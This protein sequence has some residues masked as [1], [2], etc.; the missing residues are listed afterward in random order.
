M[1]V[2]GT[3]AKS[4]NVIVDYFHNPINP[5]GIVAIT[6]T[7]SGNRSL[8]GLGFGGKF[9]LDNKIDL[10]SVK[11][12]NDNWFQSIPE[13]SFALINKIIELKGYK[14]TVAYGSSMG[15]YAAIQ[16]SKKFNCDVVV[17]LSPQYTILEEFDKRW[18]SHSKKIDWKYDITSEN[19]SDDCKYVV[20]YDT[21]DLDKEHADR[22]KVLFG[23]DN[24]TGVAIPFGGHPVSNYLHES[25]I[26]K[27][28]VLRIFRRQD[29]GEISL[30]R[31]KSRSKSYLKNLSTHLHKKNKLSL[32]LA[33]INKAIDLDAD[34]P[35]Y[36]VHKST[37]LESMGRMSESIEAL[38]RAAELDSNPLISLRI[39]KLLVGEKRFSEALQYI[40]S[41]VKSS[42][43]MAA[44][45]RQKSE[46]LVGLEE[47]D[48][49]IESASTASAL[50]S[51]NP[52]YRIHLG[53][54]YSKQ[55]KFAEALSQINEGLAHSPNVA[56]LYR[57]KVELL[58][59]VGDA[60]A[61]NLLL[62][63]PEYAAAK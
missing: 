53:N 9:L 32:S 25:G 61:A 39:S 50:D 7:P 51:K 63:T 21:Y 38:A 58:K 44:L 20:F 22:L 34:A 42:G 31:N 30:R 33:I 5:P 36:F 17:A 28:L 3:I 47:I 26:L 14:T 56:A 48:A 12:N 29:F 18:E 23:S 49:A 4:P 2:N 37:L 45:H 19:L 54:L 41:G 27:E 62:R 24:F 46:I 13:E 6:F 10:I 1:I 35:T 52:F 15:G 59:R 40:E 60:E 43:D 11:C 16:F 55:G 8:E 57:N